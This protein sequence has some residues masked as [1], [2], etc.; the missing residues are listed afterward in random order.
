M[1]FAVE[2][3]EAFEADLDE[4]VTYLIGEGVSQAALALLDEVENAIES[5]GSN[6][7]LHAISRKPA[8]RNRELREFLVKR[9]VI[10]YEVAGEDVVLLRLFHQMRYYE[11]FLM[12]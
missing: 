9:H 11:R 10:V 8:L 12:E 1:A 4:V 7:Y 6:P 3:T 2:R 5:L